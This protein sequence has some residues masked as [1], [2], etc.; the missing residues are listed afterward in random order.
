MIE[1]M[2]DGYECRLPTFERSFAC[3]GEQGWLLNS[4]SRV[5][6]PR[7]ALN[8]SDASCAWEQVLSGHDGA[9]PEPTLLCGICHV[10]DTT[11]VRTISKH[12]QN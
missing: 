9:M 6:L 11:R 3:S 4:S 12:Y 8:S 10:R 5:L 7:N 2:L 1:D